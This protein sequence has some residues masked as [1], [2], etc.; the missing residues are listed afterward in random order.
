MS[1]WAYRNCE[2]GKRI[3]MNTKCECGGDPW[4]INERIQSNMDKLEK[5]KAEHL[6]KIERIDK[7]IKRLKR[8]L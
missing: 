8:Q 5:E 4:G 7:A 6:E 3:H 2:C 1:N